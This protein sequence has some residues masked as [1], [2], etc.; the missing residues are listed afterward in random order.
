[1]A[2]IIEGQPVGNARLK[3]IGLVALAVALLVAAIGIIQRA[4]AEHRLRATVAEQS[5][6][7]VSIV[8]PKPAT[9]GTGI[10]L[11]AQVQAYNSAPIFARTG[12]YVQ[13]W[14]VDIGDPVR[15]GQ[16]LAILEAPEVDQQLAMSKANYQTAVA[17]QRLAKSTAVRWQTLLGRDAVSR[18][19][20]DEKNGDLAAKSAVANAALADVKRIEAVKGFT[21]LVSPFAGIVT[22]RAAQIGALVT[23]GNASAQPM[24]TVSDVHA[25]RVYVRVPQGYSAQVRPGLG[26]TMTVPEYP[27]RTFPVTVARTAQAVDTSSGTVLV[28]LSAANGDRA[29]KPG[30]YAQ[31]HFTSAGGGG[32]RLPG[33]AVIFNDNGTTIAVLGVDGRVAVRPVKVARDEG[34]TVVIDAGLSPADRVIDTPPDSLAPGDRVEV[35]EA[36]AGGG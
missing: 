2:E 13:R 34:K 36:T 5:I 16:V 26:A 7:K 32:F 29:L 3:R 6:E 25:M 20:A 22:S 17:N 27:G 10:T 18:Q 14:L 33:S 1:M 8:H 15:E 31:V 23:A 24:F 35:V 4:R 21:R 9:G 30:A 28:E 12:G 11:P 19:E